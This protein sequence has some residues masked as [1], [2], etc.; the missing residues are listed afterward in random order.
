[1]KKPS[2]LLVSCRYS[3][4]CY[5]HGSSQ[6]DQSVVFFGVPGPVSFCIYFVKLELCHRRSFDICATFAFEARKPFGWIVFVGRVSL[7]GRLD[8]LGSVG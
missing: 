8:G 6:F 4:M 2:N 7:C 5:I 1:M 3:V